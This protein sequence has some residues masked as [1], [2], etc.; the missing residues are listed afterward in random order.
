MIK[1]YSTTDVTSDYEAIQKKN[2]KNTAGPNTKK[3][4]VVQ[5]IK[6]SSI[7]N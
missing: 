3:T 1:K 2:L 5:T 6:P 4:E 7:S